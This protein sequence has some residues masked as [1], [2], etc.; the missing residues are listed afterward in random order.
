MENRPPPYYT[1]CL[2]PLTVRQSLAEC[3]S[4]A[5]VRHR[6]LPQTIGRDMDQTLQTMFSENFGEIHD[7]HLLMQYLQ[8]KG[9]IDS[10]L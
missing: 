8:E 2:V 6:L 4:F 10:I 5:D 7:P 1:D 3:P 9:I